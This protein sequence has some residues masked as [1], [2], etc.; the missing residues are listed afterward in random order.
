M[1]YTADT[2]DAEHLAGPSPWGSSSPKA[3]RTSFPTSSDDVP[4]SPVQAPRQSPYTSEQGSP[5][6][7]RYQD[8]SDRAYQQTATAVPADEDGG[9]LNSSQHP[10]SMP[11]ASA[12]D[13]QQQRPG[14][15][16]YQPKRQQRTVPQYKLQAKITALERSGRKDPVLRFDV[17]VRSL[18]YW[19]KDTLLSVLNRPIYQN[20]EP[21]SSAMS[22]ALIPNSPSLQNT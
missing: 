10:Q 19:W 9:L 1:N 4:Q 8:A 2:N 13:T 3:D 22:A 6:A 15:A 14:A 17:Y 7:S 5:N 20:S 12:E 21:H 16:R 18:C 11:E